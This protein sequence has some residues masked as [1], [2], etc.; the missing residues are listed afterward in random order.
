[1][2][3]LRYAPGCL[4]I[5]ALIG[6]RPALADPINLTGFVQQ[7]FNPATNPNVQV[8][9]VSNNPLNLGE[10][11][12]IP[13]NGWVSGWAIQ[14]IRTYYSPSNDT[15]YVGLDGFKNASNQYAIFGDADG[16]GNPGQA[17]PQMAAQGGIDSAHLGGDKSIAL[18]FAPINTANP[19]Q[20]GTP[21]VVAGVPADKTKVGSGTTDGFTVSQSNGSSALQYS[22]AQQLPQFTGNLAYD[23]AAAHPQLEFTIPNFSKIPGLNGLNGYWL[24]LYAG[25]AQDVVAGEVGTGW[26]KMPQPE[27][28]QIPEPAAWL[29]WMVLAGGAAWRYRHSRW[30]PRP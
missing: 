6:A 15:L 5:L 7:D 20:P 17:S 4:I 27:G 25:S 1:M 16:N 8:V 14:D 9:P 19:S 3:R 21:A 23:P 2:V 26:V 11:A 28:Q 10:A 24:N 29:A 18:S 13:A 30:A 22:F 12:F